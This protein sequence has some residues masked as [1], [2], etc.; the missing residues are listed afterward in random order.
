[1]ADQPDKAQTTEPQENEEY[2]ATTIPV[3]I[4]IDAK[5]AVLSFDEAEE[6][7]RS[8]TTLAIGPCGCRKEEQNC[9]APIDVC[10]ALDYEE[11][12]LYEGFEPVS[13]ERALEALRT[14]HE[15]GLVHLAYRK[16]GKPITEF[17]SCCSCCC[18]MFKRLKATDYHEAIVES[19]FIAK[20]DPET[21]VGCG[22]CVERCPFDAW[23]PSE[24][25]GAP[26]LAEG[27]C[28]GCGVCVTACPADAISL[29]PREPV[30]TSS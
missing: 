27:R 15:A 23:L 4:D 8:A 5:Q 17:C 11:R 24:N 16:P 26:S 10:L 19:R 2:I 13:V 30:S 6:I 14:S 22:T 12:D 18:W 20:Q 3:R 1:M 29:R 9:D 21:C 7:L 28:F 25:G